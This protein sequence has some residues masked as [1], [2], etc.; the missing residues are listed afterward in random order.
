MSNNDKLI[1]TRIEEDYVFLSIKKEYIINLAQ[2]I[3]GFKCK[4]LD[5]EHFIRDFEFQIHNHTT[6]NS[7]EA[8]LSSVEEL[9]EEIV[10]EAC[11]MA[12]EEFVEIQEED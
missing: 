3:P 1:E 8:D 5:E 7:Q 2:T 9:I 11:E 10:Q 4:V 6:S 12:D